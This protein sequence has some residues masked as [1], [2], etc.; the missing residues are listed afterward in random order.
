MNLSIIFSYTLCALIIV[1][2]SEKTILVLKLIIYLLNG[3]IITE[4]IYK[5]LHRFVAPKLMANLDNGQYKWYYKF[6]LLDSFYNIIILRNRK[7]VR[8]LLVLKLWMN[9]IKLVII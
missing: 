7:P 8:R 4:Y 6:I 5:I 1:Q 3:L 9:A 2:I